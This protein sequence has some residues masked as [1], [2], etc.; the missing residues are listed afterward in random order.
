MTYGVDQCRC[1]GVAIKPRG[2]QD[3]E[4]YRKALRNPTM[5]E[6]EWRRRGYLA[7]PTMKQLD[8]PDR[9]CC[10]PC[11]ERETR[12]KMRPFKRLGTVIGGATIAFTLIW[13]F[14]T[15]VTR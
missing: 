9:G 13:I 15:Y 5:P 7:A 3:I 2:P 12:R 6:A 10:T 11:A 8:N 14:V 1:C 4:N